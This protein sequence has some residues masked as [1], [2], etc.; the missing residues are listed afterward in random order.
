LRENAEPDVFY[1]SIPNG[2]LRNARVAQKMSAEGLFPGVAD[3]CF[4]LSGGRAAWLEMKTEVGSLSDY[5]LG[6]K[7]RC[8]RLGHL[9]GMARS[10]D[11]AIEVLKG[12]GVL[13]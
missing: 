11:E 5:Q 13:K 7:A 12:W 2:G 9:W 1:F 6:F 3:L 8:V 4:M 10:V